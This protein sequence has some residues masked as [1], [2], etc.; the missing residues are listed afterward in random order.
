[1]AIIC[2]CSEQLNTHYVC[3]DYPP[4]LLFIPCL[5]AIIIHNRACTSLDIMQ[6]ADT[7]VIKHY[8]IIIINIRLPQYVN[9]LAIE[10]FNFTEK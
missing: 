5:T 7:L 3:S 10:L 1:M 4:L 6:N 8:L 2:A 9:A